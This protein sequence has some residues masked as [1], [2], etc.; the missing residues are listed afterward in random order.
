MVKMRSL[1]AKG[2]SNSSTYTGSRDTNRSETKECLHD[3]VYAKVLGDPR[4]R[5]P[6]LYFPSEGG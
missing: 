1:F 4:R 2:S 5:G 3:M 6:A